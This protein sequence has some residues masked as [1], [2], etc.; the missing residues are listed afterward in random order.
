MADKATVKRGKVRTDDSLKKGSLKEKMY[1]VLRTAYNV[2]KGKGAKFTGS[3]LAGIKAPGSLFG[4]AG[5]KTSYY[6]DID[7]SDSRFKEFH[8]DAKSAL[9]DM[10]AGNWTGKTA[11]AMDSFLG[12]QRTG[13]GR[14]AKTPAG[15]QDVSF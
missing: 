14:G 3:R 8:S 2:E 15:I 10:K 11:K 7:E 12:L 6:W 9:S 4:G 5:K 1:V 13:G